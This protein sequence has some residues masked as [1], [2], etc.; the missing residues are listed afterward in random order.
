MNCKCTITFDP[1]VPGRICNLHYAHIAAAVDAEREACAKIA[2]ERAQKAME[3]RA[4][5]GAQSAVIARNVAAAIRAR[6]GK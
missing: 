4:I 2:D 5:A 3:A 6:G 1:K